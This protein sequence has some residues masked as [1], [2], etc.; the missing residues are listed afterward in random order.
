L[1]AE[2][3]AWVE[4]ESTTVAALST[5]ET[6]N[7]WQTEKAALEKA[8]DEALSKVKVNMFVPQISTF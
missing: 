7:L 8:R 1:I 2:K 4:R 6:A 5:D 3:A